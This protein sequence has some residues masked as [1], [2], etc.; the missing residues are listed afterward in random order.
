MYRIY[1]LKDPRI[2]GVE[3]I[4]YVG[5]TGMSLSGRF[6]FHLMD[7][8]RD[9]GTTPRW[10]WLRQLNEEGVI[11]EIEEVERL[12]SSNSREAADRENFWMDH[13]EARGC[14]LLNVNRGGGGLSR[15]DGRGGPSAWAICHFE[16]IPDKVIAEHEGVCVSTVANWRREQGFMSY[17]ENKKLFSSLCPEVTLVATTWDEIVREK[18]QLEVREIPGCSIYKGWIDRLK[19]SISQ[20]RG[21]KLVQDEGLEEAIASYCRSRLRTLKTDMLLTGHDA[22]MELFE[23]WSEIQD[24]RKMCSEG[25]TL[26]D[27]DMWIGKVVMHKRSINSDVFQYDHVMYVHDR[28][29]ERLREERRGYER[30]QQIVV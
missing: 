4:R 19:E 15:G 17:S 13:Y 28:Y 2:E 22:I 7:A 16:K 5:A 6:K 18:I 3:A 12:W 11:P 20:T 29:A 8:N 23:L 14:D 1:V 10:K 26:D 27:L 24:E 9:H 30:D 21:V 25:I